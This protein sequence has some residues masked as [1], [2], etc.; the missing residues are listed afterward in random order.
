MRLFYRSAPVFMALS[1]ALAG[2]ADS[3]PPA[4]KGPAGS[5]ADTR[6]SSSGTAATDA[7]AATDVCLTVDGMH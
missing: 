6:A 4:A 3:T 7:T 5:S 2:C 1:V